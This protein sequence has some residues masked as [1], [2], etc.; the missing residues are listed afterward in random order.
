MNSK[1]YKE[2]IDQAE[3]WELLFSTQLGIILRG[4]F[5]L[6]LSLFHT[7]NIPTWALYIC[8]HCS[9]EIQRRPFCIYSLCLVLYFLTSTTLLVK[10]WSGHKPRP[11]TAGSR[12]QHRQLPFIGS[13]SNSNQHCRLPF[14]GFDSNSD[15]WFG[16]DSDPWTKNSETRR[17]TYPII[18][19]Q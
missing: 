5:S 17:K 3:C 7:C 10:A 2:L 4:V 14:V 12:N 8:T 11:I 1:D 18:I 19:L 9:L 6:S 13:D 16:P 15:A